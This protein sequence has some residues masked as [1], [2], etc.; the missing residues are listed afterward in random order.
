MSQATTIFAGV[1]A[2]ACTQFRDDELLDLPATV[3]RLDA[4]TDAGVHGLVMLGTVGENYAPAKDEKLAVLKAT[5]GHVAG[6]VPVV[7]GVAETRTRDAVDFAKAAEGLG[8]SGLMVMP[9][10]VY[11]SDLRE[12][13]RHFKQVAAG[14]GRPVM[15]YNNPVSY[16]V[17]LRPADF[18]RL[19]DVENVAAIKESSND[20]RR[21]TDLINLYGDRFALLCGVDD[22]VLESFVLGATGWVYGSERCRAPRLD[23]E[24][25]ERERIPKVIRHA[26]ANRPRP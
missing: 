3:A 16:R 21:V 24:G 26:V 8:V 17:D 12:N 4:M 23:L 20:P 15:I 6:R 18:A 10:L 9:A 7:T 5:V 14:V 2:A 1:L 25:A 13:L 11:V 19:A 22:L